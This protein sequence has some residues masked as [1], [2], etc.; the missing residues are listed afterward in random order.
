MRWMVWECQFPRGSKDRRSTRPVKTLTLICLGVLLTA[1]A[2]PSWSAAPTLEHFHPPG[3][4][5][6][7]TNT[8]RVTGK[9]E[10]WPP[11]I[12]VDA[13]GID[14]LA[15]TNKG[16]FQVIVSPEATPGVRLIRLHNEEG[17]S[18]P[19][20]LAIGVGPELVEAEPNDHFAKA[21]VIPAL[22]QTLSGRLEKNG[23]VDSFAVALKAGEQLEARID[24]FVLMSRLDAVL[25]LF[26][27]NGQ[28][29][30]WN[31]DFATI[32]PRLT[33][34]ADQD[35]T[36]V[37]QV[38][39]FPYPATAD[40]RLTGGD[41]AIY[42]LHVGRSH[43][44]VRTKSD[45]DLAAAPAPLVELP[46]TVR[47]TVQ[48]SGEI[49]RVRLQLKKNEWITAAVNAESIGSPLDAWLRI[50]DKDGKQIVR[51]DDANESRDPAL[52]WKVP[53]D[54][55]YTFALGSLTRQAGAEYYFQL[56]VARVEPDYKAV[57]AASSM[58]VKPGT[59][60][61][62]KLT[63]TRLRGFTNALEVAAR[64]LPAGLKCEPVAVSDKGGEVKL[65]LIAPPD[66]APHQGGFSVG[67][68]DLVTQRERAVPFMLT[69]VSMDN[70]VPGGY[71]VLLADR[72]E[73]LWLTV[74]A[75]E[76]PAG[77]A[78]TSAK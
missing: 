66:G 71:R 11:K 38:F 69:G 32:D 56:S 15:Q 34:S 28:Q 53:A 20:P 68:R 43:E 19:R 33:W 64:D 73:V 23:D 72:T 7:S 76:K 74:L 54:G 1:L 42:Q 52:E 16:E 24:S 51:N 31:H 2:L 14:F 77:P 57:A 30:A 40:V 3:V 21:E 26:T 17:T 67:V 55:E 70:G 65:T 59:T 37:V 6:A 29:L 48:K 39:G 44:P 47:G 12:W 78:E 45:F 49:E 75:V 22:P 58:A 25:R 62:F 4:A 36:V 63:V 41:G 5:I 8:V 13:P 35:Q 27:T 50:D 18:E 46:V 9:F 60:N 61:E 10:P